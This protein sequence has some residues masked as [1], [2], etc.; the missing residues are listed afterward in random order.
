VLK[1]GQKILGL[2]YQL[3]KLLLRGIKIILLHDR[4]SVFVHIRSL[5]VICSGDTLPRVPRGHNEIRVVFKSSEQG[6]NFRQ[7][8]H[9]VE[10]HRILLRDRLLWAKLSLS[11]R[12]K[13]IVEISHSSCCGGSRDWMII[14]I[15][16]VFY[17][18]RIILA[19]ESNCLPL[20]YNRVGG[21]PSWKVV[22]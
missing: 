14:Y 13:I 1:F 15:V 11:L 12:N 3:Q 18:F 4:S 7:A 9:L 21:L 10:G 17:R 22:S 6:L 8:S 19:S 20:R 2:T 16:T 5:L